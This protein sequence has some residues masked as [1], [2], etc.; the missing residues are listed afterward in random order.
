MVNLNY[1]K[2][3]FK[4]LIRAI[5]LR[6]WDDTITENKLRLESNCHEKKN[7]AIN[8]KQKAN[9]HRI[10]HQYSNGDLILIIMFID[11]RRKQKKMEDPVT[12]GSYKIT[13]IL[14]NETIRILRGLY[15]KTISIWRL[16]TY[17]T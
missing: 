11:E 10:H 14:R 2:Y 5:S 7:Q 17:C 4:V 15:E 8:D 16:I 1:S 12:E 13:S 3:G 9:N 6:L